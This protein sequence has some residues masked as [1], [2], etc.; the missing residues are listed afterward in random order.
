MWPF[1]PRYL[2]QA[3]L[4]H[5]GVTRFLDY[6]R[7]ILPP[8]KLEEIEAQRTE[9]T[10]A[11]KARDEAKINTLNDKI[12]ELCQ[13][14]LPTLKNSDI[15][16]NIEVFF[17]AI[18][19]AL[20]IRAYIAQPFQ[21]PTGSMQ[22]TLNGYNA[23]GTA[24]D[25]SPNFLKRLWDRKAGTSY[26]NVVSDHD[27]YL[28]DGEYV[29][30]HRWLLLF[31]Y[32]LIHFKDGYTI[33]VS[34]P[35]RQLEGELGLSTYLN[36]PTHVALGPDG[37][38]LRTP[39]DRRV[40][41]SEAGG[42]YVSK[43]QLLARGVLHSGDH[44][45][46]NKFAYHFRQPKRGEVWVFTTKHIRGI[47]DQ[48]NF[49]KEQ[50]SQHYIKRLVGV[51]GDHWEVRPPE[52]WI[53]GKAA[54]EFGMKRVAAR[55]GPYKTGYVRIHGYPGSANEGT[56]KADEYFAMGDNSTNSLDGRY[57]GPVPERNVV[58]PA[59]FCYWPLGEHWGPIW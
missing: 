47:E 4:L 39:D 43:G 13:R 7:D 22:P 26:I 16:D 25:T 18:V 54:E 57:W 27:G 23:E 3:K 35:K 55:E 20:G 40:L 8:A 59:L 45:L 14:A 36:A 12:N 32:S 24:E 5:K 48:G 38:E 6:K 17:V 11:M 51:P 34:A 56:L 1:T 41:I 9:L 58:G 37:Q 29:T 53:N 2:K 21:I 44:I 28:A 33:S 49:D 50:G 10:A 19:V 46:V 30:E 15:A 31:T 52:L 42:R